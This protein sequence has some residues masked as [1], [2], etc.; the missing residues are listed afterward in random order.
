MGGMTQDEFIAAGIWLYGRLSWKADL[1]RALGRSDSTIRRYA[2]GAL[3]IPRTIAL[4]MAQLKA[5][6]MN[7]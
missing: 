3:P 7:A 4:S 1:A 6:K 5:E 2:N